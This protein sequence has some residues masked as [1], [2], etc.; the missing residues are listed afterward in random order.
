MGLL[1]AALPLLVVLIVSRLP[2]APAVRATIVPAVALLAFLAEWALFSWQSL[3]DDGWEFG[4]A[5]VV[6][7]P[8]M[9]A[10]L[11]YVLE[12]V[13]LLWRRW[14]RSRRPAAAEL[15]RLQD[16][17]AQVSARAWAAL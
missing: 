12:H 6:L 9:V 4:L 5:A 10:A 1:V 13:A 11:F 8:F 15:A 2:I 14:R 16:L 3:R 7:F 17:R